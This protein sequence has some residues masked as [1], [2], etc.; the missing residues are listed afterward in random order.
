MGGFLLIRKPPKEGEAERLFATS[1]DVFRQKGLP[2][3][4]VHR[5]D[6]YTLF[7]FNKKNLV[8]A[9]FLSAGDR[10]FVALTGTGIYKE[11]T[12]KAALEEILS[13]YRKG[14]LPAA[15]FRG[16]YCLLIGDGDILTLRTDPG[17]LYHVFGDT[18]L[19]VVSS[20]F[21]AVL[22][23]QKSRTLAVQEFFEYAFNGAFYGN[24]TFLDE[25]HL[26]DST[27]VHQLHP[28]VQQLQGCPS[29]TVTKFQDISFDRQV[30]QV[31]GQLDS[32]FRIL[33]NIFGD[34]VNCPLTGGFDSRLLLALCLHA[35]I[36]PGLFLV[37]VKD[38][39]HDPDIARDMAAAKGLDLDNLKDFPT[40][41][42]DPEHHL[43]KQNFYLYDG[44]GTGGVFRYYSGLDVMNHIRPE[45]LLLDGGGGEIYRNIKV[46]PDRSF[47]MKTYL[48]EYYDRCEPACC[49][50]AFTY[51]EYLDLLAHKALAAI[52]AEAMTISRREAEMVFP[53]FHLKYWMG[54]INSMANQFMYYFTPYAEEDVAWQSFEIPVRYKTLGRFEAALIRQLDPGLAKF[55][56]NY[57]FNFFDGPSRGTERR[58]QLRMML[59]PS[60]KKQFKSLIRKKR[61]S[62]PYARMPLYLKE[63]YV[64]GLIDLDNLTVTRYVDIKK[65]K[66]PLCLSR[67]WTVELLLQGSF[68]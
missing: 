28:V 35:G 17:G 1:L 54:I 47:G 9:N 5:A 20:S 63:E 7:L 30:E 14:K 41:D 29:P 39:S 3:A 42:D 48:K 18:S 43:L 60:A 55:R 66:D 67:I 31:A 27:H 49:M 26:L 32:H 16:N 22:R 13:D 4:H 10:L 38:R 37:S 11:K 33:K 61:P 21:L 52:G 12:G 25:I 19:E 62:D 51:E 36:R 64:K 56:S 8:E 6:G 45:P 23:A 50:P 57:G 34:H 59:P 53:L 2:E 44:H 46:V 58:E 68:K 65:V 24:K 40:L 15:H